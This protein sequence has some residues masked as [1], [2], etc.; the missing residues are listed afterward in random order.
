MSLHNR[1]TFFGKYVFAISENVYEPAED[2]FLLARWLLKNKGKRVL[3]M[4]TG[5]G[6]LAVVAA[7]HASRVVAVDINPYAVACAKKN[8]K[9]NGFAEKV[10][11]RLSDLFEA[12]ESQEEFDCILFN[13][14]YLRVEIGKD[15]LDKAW[16]G[17]KSGRRIIDRFLDEAEEY[18]SEKGRILL[19]QSSLSN[20]E[21]TLKRF[22][23]QRLWA[24]VVDEDKLAFEKIVLIEARKQ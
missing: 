2:T 13:A 17:G 3:D 22:A 4:G 16:S 24:L 7:E 14:P 15:W 19:V 18:L 12:V 10:D 5:C 8:I 21:K 11:T 1:T 20:V 23:Q 9:C 6:L